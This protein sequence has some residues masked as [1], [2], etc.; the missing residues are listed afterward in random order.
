MTISP[1]DLRAE[2]QDIFAALH[3]DDMEREAHLLNVR[4]ELAALRSL[5]RDLLPGGVDTYV[6]LS[7]LA[8]VHGAERSLSNAL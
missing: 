3:A 7:L 6:R 1:K 8:A 5:I 2:L 4:C